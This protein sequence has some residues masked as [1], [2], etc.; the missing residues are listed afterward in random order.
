MYIPGAKFEEHCS[1][2]EIFLIQYFAVLVKQFVMS[3][4]SSFANYKNVNASISK[5]KKD[6]PKRKTPFCFILK[7]LLP[8]NKKQLFFTS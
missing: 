5:T 1:I 6:N 2:P 7:S 4:L 3:S 8:V